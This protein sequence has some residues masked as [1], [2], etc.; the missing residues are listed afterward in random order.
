MDDSPDGVLVD[1]SFEEMLRGQ[2]VAATRRPLV[3][4]LIPATG[5]RSDQG[6]RNSHVFIQTEDVKQV[7]DHW[8]LVPMRVDLRSGLDQLEGASGYDL[9][10]NGDL[11]NISS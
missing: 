1:V 4:E 11:G 9:G 7:I 8:Y 6:A 10:N 2:S 3:Y 5:S